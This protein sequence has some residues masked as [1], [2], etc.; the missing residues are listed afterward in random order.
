M[1]KYGGVNAFQLCSATAASCSFYV[2]AGQTCTD[3][4]AA[5]MGTCID[6]WDADCTVMQNFEG[7]GVANQSQV[8]ICSLP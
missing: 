8:C 3:I 6:G 5:L 4:C 1:M 2:E 7:C